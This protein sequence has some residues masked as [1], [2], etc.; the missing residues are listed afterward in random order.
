M[1]PCSCRQPSAA[2]PNLSVDENGGDEMA[3]GQ[4]KKEKTN[5]SKLSP[6]EKK[7]KKATQKA[8]KAAK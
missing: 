7:A 6:K 3:K 2:Q 4:V 8:A 1:Y 5:K